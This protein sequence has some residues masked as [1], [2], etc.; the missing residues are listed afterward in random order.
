MPH[1]IRNFIDKGITQTPVTYVKGEVHAQPVLIQ[2][3][4]FP[5]SSKHLKETEKEKERKT[6]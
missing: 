3:W 4:K 6:P 2:E 1:R 5:S